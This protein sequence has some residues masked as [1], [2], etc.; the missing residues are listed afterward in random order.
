MAGLAKG[1]TPDEILE[2]DPKTIQESVGGLPQ[3]QM[4]CARLSVQTLNA[5]LD[6]YMRKSRKRKT[7]MDKIAICSEGPGLDDQLDP[8]F[9]RAAGFIIIDPV[10]MI[11]EYV[12][13]GASQAAAQGAGIQAAEILSRAGVRAVLTGSVGPKAFRVLQAAGIKIGQGLENVTVRQALE[14][15]QHGRVAWATQPNR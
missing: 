3:D 6:D 8:R 10:T 4:H 9:G 14:L 2:I 11:F 5:A 12:D 7:I 1:K 13:N 15:Y